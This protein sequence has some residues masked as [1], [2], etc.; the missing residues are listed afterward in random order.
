MSTVKVNSVCATSEVLGVS[1]NSGEISSTSDTVTVISC[2]TGLVPSV[3]ETVA[4]NEEVVSKS[5]FSKKVITPVEG[6]IANSSPEISYV[7]VASASGSVA[8]AVPIAN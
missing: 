1:S 6:S 2:S 3:T 8:L 7:R 4:V 5:G